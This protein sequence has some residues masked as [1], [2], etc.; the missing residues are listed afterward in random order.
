MLVVLPKGTTASTYRSYYIVDTKTNKI[1]LDGTSKPLNVNNVKSRLY[2]K[3]RLG[4]N[5]LKHIPIDRLNILTHPN[6][7]YRELTSEK[8]VKYL[9]GVGTVGD[10]RIKLNRMTLKRCKSF[11]RVYVSNCGKHIYQVTYG[12]LVE[13]MTH[14]KSGYLSTS[15]WDDN[16]G[17][18]RGMVQHRVVMDAWHETFRYHDDT[19]V[20]H[21]DHNRRNNRPSNLQVVTREENS[22]L[23]WQ[24]GYGKGQ[25]NSASYLATLSPSNLST[26]E[27]TI[28]D[29]EICWD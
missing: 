23:T 16:K 12:V 14:D 22:H 21:I 25:P 7:I 6:V 26:N 28:Q 18:S 29:C 2:Y 10:E 20:D 1:Y 4:D 27:C 24:R 19:V 3:I 13:Q 8:G 17:K 15:L 5:K 11:P 9:R